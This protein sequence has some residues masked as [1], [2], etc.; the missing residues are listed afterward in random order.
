M[1]KATNASLELLTNICS[2]DDSFATDE[3]EEEEEEKEKLPQRVV[4]MLRFH[5][6]FDLLLSSLSSPILSPQHFVVEDPKNSI[7]ILFFFIIVVF[8]IIVINGD[9]RRRRRERRRERRRDEIRVE[10]RV[11]IRVSDG[12][13]VGWNQRIDGDKKKSKSFTD[14]QHFPSS[15]TI[16]RESDRRRME[17]V[18]QY[19]SRRMERVG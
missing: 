12:Q 13:F 8:F 10:I 18:D 11:K 16:F 2:I 9:E 3:G 4:E 5:I 14:R 19:L 1:L 15:R 6:P 7:S 17:N